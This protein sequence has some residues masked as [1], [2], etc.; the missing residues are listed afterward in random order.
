MSEGTHPC[1]RE[2]FIHCLVELGHK[3]RPEVGQVLLLLGAL[4]ISSLVS[5]EG[6]GRECWFLKGNWGSGTRTCGQM[7]GNGFC[8]AWTVWASRQA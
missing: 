4:I 7:L 6:Y 1:S 2:C 5:K 3:T 8:A